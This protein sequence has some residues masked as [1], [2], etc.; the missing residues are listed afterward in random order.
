MLETAS[1]FP[2]GEE[3][4]VGIVSQRPVN[5]ASRF[6]PY[7]APSNKR[8]LVELAIT[9]VPFLG[10][11][12]GAVLLLSISPWLLPLAVIP[13]AF[14]LIRVFIIQHDCGHG[15]MFASHRLNTW[16]GRVLGVLTLTPYAYWRHSH[17]VHH[18]SSGHLDR[19]GIGDVPTMTVAEFKQSS[20][21]RRLGY[22]FVR[23][24]LILFGVG[25][26][27]VFL[28]QQRWPYLYERKGL[29]PW[30]SVM[31]TNLAVL[32]LAFGLS[33]WVGWLAFL[34]VEV[35]II[36][37]TA[38]IG[39]WLF[40]VQHQFED[41]YWE[42]KDVWKHQPAALEGSSFYD[43]PQP[44]AWL[45]GNIGLHHVHHVSSGIP[46]YRLPDVLKAFP[47]LR[48]MGRLGLSD[49]FKCARL[50][51]WDEETKRLVPFAQAKQA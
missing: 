12:W 11:W 1:D 42:G 5:W 41:T 16:V 2:R 25:P 21:L 17:A 32:L 45:S 46:F 34:A 22:R 7:R 15:A 10:L 23:H 9:L 26:A 20:R 43:L 8:A 13:A 28:I 19:R 18:A 6:A 33:Q 37:L 24:P 14:F 50:K 31:G 44:L 47:E 36:S 4:E 51:L 48:Q 40:Y 29:W 38:S 39:V 35:A 30:I 49:S 3:G 27:F